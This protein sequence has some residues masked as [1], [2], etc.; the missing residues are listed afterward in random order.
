MVF[1]QRITLA[2]TEIPWNREE[3]THKEKLQVLDFLKTHSGRC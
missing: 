2:V 1:V 3:L